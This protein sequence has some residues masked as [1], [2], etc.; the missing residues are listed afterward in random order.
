MPRPNREML[1]KVMTRAQK[2]KKQGVRNPL[3][4]AWADFKK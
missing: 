1:K 4:K 3:K 2:Y